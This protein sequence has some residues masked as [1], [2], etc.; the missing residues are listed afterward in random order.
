VF[1][2]LLI[3]DIRSVAG[4]AIANDERLLAGCN[5]GM[6]AGDLAARET[7]IVRLAAADLEDSFRD[8]HDPPSQGVGDFQAGIRHKWSLLQ[9]R[10]MAHGS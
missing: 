7:Q 2:D 8:W 3:V 5:L 1:G 9:S 10:L 4:V 6:I